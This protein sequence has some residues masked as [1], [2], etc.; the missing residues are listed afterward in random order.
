MADLHLLSRAG[1]LV[2][3]SCFRIQT[4]RICA[5]RLHGRGRPFHEL[6]PNTTMI[7]LNDRLLSPQTGFTDDTSDNTYSVY[8]RWLLAS[9]LFLT[10]ARR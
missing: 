4:R 3:S 2:R 1:R 8:S 7:Y 9:L 6:L 5:T 10:F